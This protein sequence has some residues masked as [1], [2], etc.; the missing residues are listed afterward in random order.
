M[1]LGAEGWLSLGTPAAELGVGWEAESPTGAE[2]HPAHMGTRDDRRTQRSLSWNID[3]P[4]RGESPRPQFVSTAELPV[5]DLQD[6]DFVFLRET[7][8][9]PPY[10][11]SV[12]SETYFLSLAGDVNS[13][14]LK[15][16]S[17]SPSKG[18]TSEA[19]ASST[20][21]VLDWDDTLFP[22]TW[23]ARMVEGLCSEEDGTDD[24][25]AATAKAA[26]ELLRTARKFGEVVIVTLASS[27][28]VDQCLAFVKDAE[29]TAEVT[30]LR[31]I[32][33]QTVAEFVEAWPRA[34]GLKRAKRLNGAIRVACGR[35]PSFS[36]R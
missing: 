23:Y 12:G 24:D 2:L 21:I 14:T 3:P 33:A 19:L 26:V 22:T 34:S 5:L 28:W 18:D 17:T 13:S 31:V 27:G 35:T 16:I 36:H 4:R 15:R 10:V 29:L 8:K 9:T 6:D 32:Y 11:G 1:D 25:Y 30:A 7:K 20:L